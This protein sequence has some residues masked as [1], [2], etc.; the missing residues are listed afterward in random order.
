MS[1][2]ETHRVYLSIGSN[3]DRRQHLSAALDALAKEFGP[4]MLSSVYE[5]VSVGF[6]GDNFYNMVV[7]VDTGYPVVHLTAV[8][9]AIEQ[10]NGRSRSGA[11]F[12][13]RTLDID[14]LTY[15]QCAGLVDGVSLPRDEILKNAHVLL[16]LAEIASDEHH[17]ACQQTY[18]QLAEVFANGNKD[19]DLDGA[20]QKLWPIDFAWQGRNISFYKS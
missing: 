9:R 1:A 14:I 5:S 10:A 2:Q 16:P 20:K 7:G 4:L 18:R 6:D 3:I 13:P 12:G 17:P 11:K 19:A 15:G 8:L